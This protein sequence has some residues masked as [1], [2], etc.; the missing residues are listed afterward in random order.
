MNIIFLIFNRPELTAR[1]FETI[2]QATPERL[3]VV[4]DGARPERLGE[5]ELVAAARA[6]TELVDWP[7]DVIRDYSDV[8][9]GCG[10]RVSSGISKAFESIEDAIILEDDC[11]PDSTFFP[12]CIQLLERYKDD[13]RVMC[14]SG[15]NFQDGIP[16]GEAEANYYFSKYPH[17]WGWATWRR[18]WNHFSLDVPQWPAIRERGLLRS[19]CYS[20][21]EHDFWRRMFNRVHEGQIDTWNFPW[22]LSIWLQNGLTALPNVNLV[23]NIGFGTEATHTGSAESPFACLPSSGIQ[24]VLHPRYVCRDGEADQFTD[25]VMFSGKPPAAGEHPPSLN[26]RLKSS[27]LKYWRKGFCGETH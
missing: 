25:I 10:K 5:A 20:N 11:L 7:C 13:D 18:A 12:F 22:T 21:R 26:H 6:V 17:C 24:N 15:D 27:L 3:F 9:L 2:R 1:V 14:I 23:S 8:N 16:R 19:I 4:A